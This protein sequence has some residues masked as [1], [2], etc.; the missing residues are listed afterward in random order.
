MVCGDF[1]I[2]ADINS[3]MDTGMKNFDHCKID[4]CDELEHVIC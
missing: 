1:N 4:N 3:W 2:S